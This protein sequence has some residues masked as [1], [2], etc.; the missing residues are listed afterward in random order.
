VV[1]QLSIC[2]DKNT[3]VVPMTTR[4]EE[5]FRQRPEAVL[6]DGLNAIGRN[7]VELQRRVT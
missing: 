3:E 2:A 7:I 6:A 4:A 1:D 5:A